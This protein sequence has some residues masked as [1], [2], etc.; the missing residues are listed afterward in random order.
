MK[1][2]VA[3][4]GNAGTAIAADLALQGHAVTLLKTS[5]GSS[6]DN[7]LKIAESESIRVEE[8]DSWQTA[9]LACV[10]DRFEQAVSDAALVVVAVQTN[11]QES[12][13]RKMAP[14]LN[15]DQVLLFE[16][17]YLA[18]ALVVKHLGSEAPIV[19]ESASTPINCR[20]V[21]PGSVRISFRNFL[22]QV[23]VWPSNRMAE[24]ESVLGRIDYDWTFYDSVAEAALHNPNLIVHTV[25]GLMS[26][27][28]IEYSGG[29]YWMYRE[30]FTPHVWNMVEALDAEK[31]AVLKALGL[32]PT[33]YLESCKA[34]NTDDRSLD[35]K[36]VFFDW[37]LNDS[38]KGPGVPDSRYITEDV[39]QGLALLESLG[40]ST[41]VNTPVCSALIDLAGAALGRNFRSADSRTLEHL[42]A[43]NVKA[44]LELE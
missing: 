3:G 14:H 5:S 16:P 11:Y 26:I 10:T 12:V 44:V 38:Q 2:T 13:I 41:F 40:Q 30:V 36:Q 35:A 33:K 1:I 21:E 25:G 6:G 8:R 17:G 15:K 23:A 27:P 7:F 42:G 29:E 43:D 9:Q 4:T 28:R 20:V 34:R 19:V 32:P 39:P 37:A 24:A 22:N 31:V 18:S